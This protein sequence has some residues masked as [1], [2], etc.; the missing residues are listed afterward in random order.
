MSS[1][2]YSIG[3]KNTQ[4]LLRIISISDPQISL[5]RLG[6]AKKMTELRTIAVRGRCRVI[7]VPRT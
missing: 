7:R 4:K 5:N 2:V 3:Y 6:R 1:K